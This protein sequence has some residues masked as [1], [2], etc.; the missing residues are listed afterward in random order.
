MSVEI[1]SFFSGLGILD[2]GF[3]EA[4]FNISF[5]NEHDERFLNAYQYARRNSNHIPQFGY[6][7]KSVEEF[8]QDSIWNNLFQ[9]YEN[10]NEQQLIGFI[11]G[12]PCPDFSTAGKNAG[13]DGKH[14]QLTETYVKLI[15][16]RKPDFFVFENVKGLCQT[17]KHKLFYDK[18]KKKL[19]NA[20]YSLFDSIEN[21]LEYGAPQ[22]RE[23]L[24]LI[25]LR[26]QTFGK[27]LQYTI[28]NHKIFTM[29]EIK[30][31]DWPNMDRYENDGIRIAPNNILP[32]L[33][34]E[35]WFEANDVRNHVNSQD[36]FNPVSIERFVNVE[37]GDTRKKS[38]K[39]LHRWRF[40]PTAAYGN[41]EVHLHPYLP[42]RISVAEALAIQ[43]LPPE[44]EVLP[45]LSL[46][47]KFKMVGN[48]VPYLLAYG[49]A[50]DLYEWLL[51]Y[52]IV[53]E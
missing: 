33:T 4:G 1:F 9:N 23:R 39:R 35:H 13:Q 14:G 5:V 19:Y 15:I 48:G 41:N 34:V 46:S 2:Y 37:E 16:K 21:S 36:Y 45:E 8:L 53:E 38:F 43:S 40:S 22:N 12:P 17:K 49:I 28:G 30:A 51:P 50:M 47:A 3:E 25:G 31:C 44:F 7:N 10:R 26:R 27:R 6:S 52:T 32:E 11:G 24:I 20:G 29:N 18:M 42:R